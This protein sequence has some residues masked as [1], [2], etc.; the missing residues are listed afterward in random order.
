MSFW[1]TI[2]GLTL[3]GAT[4]A[5]CV[6]TSA[7]A[8]LAPTP[9]VDVPKDAKTLV[10][11]GG[12]FWCVEAILEDLKGVY[13]VESGYAGGKSARTTYEEVSMGTTGH[14]EAVKVF[15]DPNKISAEDLLR[16]FFTTHDPTTLNRQGPDSGTQYRSTVFYSNPE[17]KARAEK[18][19]A[20]MQSIFKDPIVTTIEPLKNYSKAEEYH[21][22][23]Y[24][25]YERASDAE[26]SKMNAGYCAAIIEPKVRKFRE[27]YLTKLKKGGQ[28]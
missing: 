16:V 1:T 20:E 19:K 7:E 25:K 12:C 2:L 17:E 8:T 4:V 22:D 21:Q 11:A 13:S 5:G 26:K 6:S 14:A 28:D 15:Y 18:I 27:K 3:V 10:V 9:P 23:Y 24:A